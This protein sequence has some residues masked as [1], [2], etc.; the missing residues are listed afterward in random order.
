MQCLSFFVSSDFHH[1]VIVWEKKWSAAYLCIFMPSHDVFLQ[2]AWHILPTTFEHVSD[3]SLHGIPFSGWVCSGWVGCPWAVGMSHSHG[4][5]YIP[6]WLVFKR[7]RQDHSK[8]HCHLITSKNM[9]SLP[10][11]QGWQHG[12]SHTMHIL[13]AI[14]MRTW[15][16]RSP[17]QKWVHAPLEPRSD[18]GHKDAHWIK[19]RGDQVVSKLTAAL[20]RDCKSNGS[21]AIMHAACTNTQTC[22]CIAARVS[23]LGKLMKVHTLSLAH[24]LTQVR[25]LMLVTAAA[26]SNVLQRG[27]QSHRPFSLYLSLFAMGLV[28]NRASRGQADT[29]MTSLPD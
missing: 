18:K 16:N 25:P 24:K 20:A 1:I 5:P 14:R 3:P 27:L 15:V 12:A 28:R 19:S 21:C 17:I 6:F 29:K 2:W 4:V 26:I 13:E 10:F 9:H 23:K 11:L 7:L 22:N 8:H